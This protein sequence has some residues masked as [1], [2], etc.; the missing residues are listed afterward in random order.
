MAAAPDFPPKKSKAG[1]EKDRRIEWMANL[2]QQVG[3]FNSFTS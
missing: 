3:T 1:A 2:R